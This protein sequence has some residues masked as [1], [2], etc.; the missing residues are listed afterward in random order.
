M[1]KVK[2]FV[3]FLKVC[4]LFIARRNFGSVIHHVALKYEELDISNL[5]KLEK[6]SLKLKKAQLDHQFLL[7]C[8]EYNVVPKFLCYNLPFT[9]EFEVKLI[10]KKLLKNAINKRRHEIYK[11]QKKLNNIQDLIYNILSGIDKFI[12]N[13]TI[14]QITRSMTNGEMRPLLVQRKPRTQF[15]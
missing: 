5:R 10:R 8:K 12:L 14:K 13:Y 11:L 9:T 6:I 15:L 4:L 2:S 3:I 1:I 7:K